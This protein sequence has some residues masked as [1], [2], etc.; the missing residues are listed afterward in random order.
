MMVP[1]LREEHHV[2]APVC[3]ADAVVISG[4]CGS[5]RMVLEGGVL[6]EGGWLADQKHGEGVLTFLDGARYVGQF[7]RDQRSGYGAFYYPNGALYCGQWANDLQH[8]NGEEHWADSSVFTGE[9]RLGGSTAVVASLGQ[10]VVATRASL[11]LMT[12]MAKVPTCGTMAA[13]SVASG[14]GTEW[15]PVAVCGGPMARC[16]K[17]SSITTGS[18]AMVPL[19]GQM[20][21][22]TTGSGTTAYNMA[23]LL[24]VH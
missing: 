14:Y 4:N 5:R 17:V 2:N 18:M 8:G 3:T 20:E 19:S 13:A 24:R 15:V 1:C 23:L 10:A 11:M 16:M 21:G 9:F 7:C 6:Y 22:S 12:C